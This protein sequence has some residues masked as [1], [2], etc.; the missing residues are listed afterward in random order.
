MHKIL[1]PEKSLLNAI[2]ADPMR[3][4]RL[5]NTLS[6]MELCGAEL[7]SKALPKLSLSTFV[8][9]H[10]AEEYRHAFFLRKLANKLAQRELDVKDTF[11]IRKSRFYLKSLNLHTCRLIKSHNLPMSMGNAFLPYL[12][13][14]YMIEMRALPFYKTYQAVIDENHIPISLKS[15][16]AEEVDH[17]HQIKEQIA[18]LNLPS[19][20]LFE[21]L[22]VEKRAFARWLF[23]INLEIKR[24]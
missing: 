23:D 16:L 19:T 3:H 11:A 15:I 5:L 10:V 14:T 13:T 20:L 22:K 18:L 9:E 12:L 6:I 8:L 17:L 1:R 2:V 7:I 21:C 4:A 24:T